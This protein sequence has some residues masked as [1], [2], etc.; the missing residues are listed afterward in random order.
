M[1]RVG[2]GRSLM[3]MLRNGVSVL[4]AILVAFALDAWWDDRVKERRT[5]VLLGAVGADGASKAGRGQSYEPSFGALSTLLSAGGLED[6][7]DIEL[8]LSLADWPARLAET[9]FELQLLQSAYHQLFNAYAA[10]YAARSAPE[11]IGARRV[12][13]LRRAVWVVSAGME[14]YTEEL[15]VLREEAAELA[16]MLGAAGPG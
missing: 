12:D 11:G 13:D 14:A 4:A 16:R 7:D 3:S 5:A 10:L 8:Q 1:S 15:L 6:V 9:D 2:Q